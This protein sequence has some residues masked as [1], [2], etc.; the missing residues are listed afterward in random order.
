MDKKTQSDIISTLPQNIIDNILCLMPIRDA[1]RTSVLSKKWQYS[2][3]SM[4]KLVFTGNMVTVSSD[5]LCGQVKNYKLASGIFHV[6]LLHNG[7]ETLVFDCSDG[8][9]RMQS[10][11]SRVIRYL[12]KGNK[13]KELYFYNSNSFYKI[14]I[15]FFT[16]QS[17]EVVHL[18]DCAFEPPLTFNKF[19]R[20]KVMTFVN[21]EVSAQMLQRFLSKCPLLEYLALDGDP[22]GVDFVEGEN[23]FTF[24][25]L[26]Q[27]VPLIKSLNTSKYYMKY[28]SAGGMPHKLPTTLANLKHL[29]SDVC[30]VKQNEISSALCMIRSAPLLVEITIMVNMLLLMVAAL[31]T[32]IDMFSN[33]MYDNETFPTPRTPTNF[34]DLEG[35]P[36]LKLDHLEMLEIQEFSNL[37]LEM[38]FV[39]LIMAKSPVLKKVRI[40]LRDNVSVDEE[41]EMLRDLI[42]LP[43]P[44]ASP[45]ARLTI[46]RP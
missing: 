2:W 1:L 31:Y 8:R 17:L 43:F 38:E 7:P 35:Y 13:V 16:L 40:V 6:L 20:L 28:L 45:S 33:Q 41:L 36:D 22:L 3:Q 21:V 26:L 10:E 11:F 5:H 19:S 12:A 46:V 39:K 18:E 42:L 44:R 15:S 4:P 27:Y 24:V 32:F 23:K 34:L 29:L 37:P 14:P 30:L 9:F 25:D